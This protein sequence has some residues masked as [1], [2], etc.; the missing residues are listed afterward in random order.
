MENHER[1]T[2]QARVDNVEKQIDQQVAATTKAVEDAHRE[3]RAVERNYSENASINR[4]EV[5]DIAESRSMIEQ[6]RQL[7]SRAAESRINSKA[8]VKNFE[9]LKRVTVFWPD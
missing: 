4:Y 1:E 9:K 5:D 6:Q 2:E 8:P 7:V 3:T